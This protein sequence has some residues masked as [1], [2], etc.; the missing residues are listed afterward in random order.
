MFSPTMFNQIVFSMCQHLFFTSLFPNYIHVFFL[1]L[2]KITFFNI[3][4]FGSFGLFFI[5]NNPN[6]PTCESVKTAKEIF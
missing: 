3:M 6:N 1:F 5:F 4:I 2:E